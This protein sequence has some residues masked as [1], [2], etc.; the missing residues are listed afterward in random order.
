MAREA[1]DLKRAIVR[2]RRRAAADQISA[3]LSTMALIFDMPLFPQDGDTA[4]MFAAGK[5]YGTP[6]VT[7]VVLALLA[8]GAVRATKNKVS[9]KGDR[10]QCGGPY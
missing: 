5:G 7:A 10:W 3:H 2:G 9:A 6:C 1:K 4:L 8:A